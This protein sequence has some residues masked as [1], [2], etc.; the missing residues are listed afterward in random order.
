MAIWVCFCRVS[1]VGFGFIGFGQ[2]RKMDKFGI[3]R[4]NIEEKQDNCYCISSKDMPS[5]F[6][7]G[8]NLEKLLHDIPGSIELL[9]E[10]NH[11]LKVKVGKVVSG[12]EMAQKQPK[13]L[14][15]QFWVFTVTE[16]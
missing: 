9:F 5:L 15:R 14:D 6:L 11:G 1:L 13:T 16:S 3:V 2:M 7:A 12:D 8:E 10:L 4:I